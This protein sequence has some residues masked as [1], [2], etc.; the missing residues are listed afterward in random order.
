MLSGK[1]NKIIY[2]KN[3]STTSRFTFSHPQIFFVTTLACSLWQRGFLSKHNLIYFTK[4]SSTGLIIQQ[5]L[6]TTCWVHALNKM[7][8]NPTVRELAF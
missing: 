4:S 2:V 5:H 8:K 1:I 3:S 6:N 7:N